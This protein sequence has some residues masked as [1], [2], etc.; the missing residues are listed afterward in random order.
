MFYKG[1]KLFASFNNNNTP[2]IDPATPYTLA[3]T[4]TDEDGDYYTITAEVE[5]FELE[6][7]LEE[8]GK[9]CRAAVLAELEYALEGAKDEE[10][11]AC[12]P[13]AHY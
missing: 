13:R 4:Y 11:E 2:A 7:E 5:G 12:D 1:N 3:V 10:A 9:P 6:V 8:P